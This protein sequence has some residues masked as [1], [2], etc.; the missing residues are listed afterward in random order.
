MKFKP[1]DKVRWAYDSDWRG[2]VL[3]YES[4]G[5]YNVRWFN[6]DLNFKDNFIDSAYLSRYLKHWSPFN[7]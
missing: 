7:C 3:N 2:I 1:G 6:I 4:G 5:I